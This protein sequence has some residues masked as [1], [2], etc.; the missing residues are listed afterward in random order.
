MKYIVSKSQLEK[1]VC[2][3]GRQP[4]SYGIIL[5]YFL[6][7]KKP[8][9]LVANGEVGYIKIRPEYKILDIGGATFNGVVREIIESKYMGKNINI[10]IQENDNE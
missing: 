7:D 10:F 3:V 2:S 5:D 9:E 4:G 1:L 6:K 8:V